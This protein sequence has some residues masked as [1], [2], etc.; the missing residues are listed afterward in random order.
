ME[1]DLENK[2]FC[3]FGLPDSGKST[4]ACFILNQYGSQAFVY[5]TLHEYPDTPFDS[6]CPKNRYSAVELDMTIR[7]VMQRYKLIVIDETNRFCPPKPAPLPPAVA[8]LNDWRAHYGATVGYICRRPVQLNT[9]LTELSHY[10]FIFTLKGKN[11]TMYLNDL[12]AGLGDAVNQL[13]LYH[14]IVVDPARNYQVYD[15]IP[16]HFK[17]D[18]KL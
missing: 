10:L 17:T 14:F 16:G 7:I 12:V 13:E 9:D 4:L 2:A 6:Y 18:K 3:I 5:D 11:D 15:P 8:D 1:L